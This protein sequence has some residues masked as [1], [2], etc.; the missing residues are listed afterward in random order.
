MD[1]NSIRK[2]PE[3]LAP[4]G[5]FENMKAVISA[6]ADAVYMG[7]KSFGARAY[8][9]NPDEEG[10]IEAIRFCHIRN[11]KLYLT[12]NTILKENELEEQLYGYLKPYYEAGLDAVIVQ[13]IGVMEFIGKHFPGLDIHVSTQC[14][15]TMAEGIKGLTSMLTDPKSVTRIVPAREL[16]LEE[17]V[18]CLCSHLTV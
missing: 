11:R 3:L 8:A 6:G 18:K 14:S 12:V 4:A 10:V 13:D 5:S 9:D 1:I 16:S 17:L 15:L 2:K 7:G